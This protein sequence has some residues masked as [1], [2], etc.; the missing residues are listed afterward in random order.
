MPSTTSSPSG[1]EA[2]L[3]PVRDLDGRNGRPA[4]VTRLVLIATVAAF[5]VQLGVLGTD[6]A[7]RILVHGAFVPGAF[8]GDPLV[9]AATPFT[10]A[11]LHG[12]PWHLVSNMVF[13]SVFADDVEDRLGSLRFAAFYLAGGAVASLA[14]GVV[15]PTSPVPLVGAS[16]AIAAVMGAYVVWTPR[17]MIQTALLPLIVPWFVLRWIARVP[18]FYLVWLPAWAYVGLW[19]ATNFVEAGSSLVT[20][21]EQLG[22]V[23]WW[24]HVGGFVFGTVVAVAAR[25]SRRA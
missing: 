13:L 6:T 25:R 19:A 18:R 20:G 14:H 5:T 11:F 9:H 1:A 3:L 10:A 2:P 8:F 22:G 7:F 16:G 4:P 24:A 21:S 23:A 12:D 17:R 15:D